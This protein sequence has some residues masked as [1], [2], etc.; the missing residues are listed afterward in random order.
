MD[1]SGWAGHA[2]HRLS[3]HIQHTMEKRDLFVELLNILC[4]CVERES[5]RERVRQPDISLAN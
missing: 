5:E 3:S 4:K 2:S 1:L